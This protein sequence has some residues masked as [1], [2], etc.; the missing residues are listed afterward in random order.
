MTAEKAPLDDT[1]DAALRIC[2]RGLPTSFWRGR[3]VQNVASFG[4]S[5]A[6]LC[7]AA[8]RIAASTESLPSFRACEGGHPKNVGFVRTGQSAGRW[9][10][11][12]HCGSAFPF[13][14]NTIHRSSPLHRRQTAASE[15]RPSFARERAPIAVARVKVA[16]NP[17]GIAA[18]TEVSSRGI[19]SLHDME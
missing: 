13:C 15:E 9:L 5:D 8:E 11:K 1:N 14:P 18:R 16:G 17:T 10:R 4:K 12:A 19:I 3:M 6:G 2:C 7:E